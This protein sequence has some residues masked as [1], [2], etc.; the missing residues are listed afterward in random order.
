MTTDGEAR[1]PQSLHRDITVIGSS[2]GGIAVLREIIAA[3]PDDYAAAAFVVI[4]L[5]PEAP[6]VLPTLLNR[7]SRIPV[8]VVESGARIRPGTVTIARPDM[9]LIVER[10][11]VLATHG[12][13]EN[14]HRPSID[15]LFRSAAVA[16]GTRVTGVVLSGMLDDGSAGL[17]A[18]K[19]RG[20]T[21]VVQDPDDAE[22]PDMPRNALNVTTV[23]Y[24]V[25]TREIAPVLTRLAREKVPTLDEPVPP[26]MA[27]EVRMA[28][29]GDSSMEQLDALGRRVPLTCPECGGS[30]WEMGNGGP[31]YR[32]HTGHAYSMNSLAAEQTVQVEAALWAGLRRLEESER[33]AR[34]MENAAL[35]RGNDRSAVYHAEIAR[36]NAAHAETLRNVLKEASAMPAREAAN[37]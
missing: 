19:N 34:H 12:P 37:E 17:W 31:R 1:I 26:G 9:H 15:V 16:F 35:A 7:I 18:I 25:P 32:C 6:S 23:D 29:Q 3:L 28:A 8:S 10:D 20:G 24:R 4:H 5:A 22:Y 30:L 33:L 13:R 21:A 11:R 36:S 14:R 2:A 27:T